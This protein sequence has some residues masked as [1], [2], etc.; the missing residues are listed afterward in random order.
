MRDI[1]IIG[2]GDLGGA[3]AHVLARRHAGTA[4]RLI[5][6]RGRVAE[7]KALDLMQSA[8][9]EGFATQLSGATDLTTAG[10]AN[11]VIVADRA[12]DA[13]WQGED[14]LRLL[15]RLREIA[16]AALILCAGA[17]Q[18]DLVDRGVRELHI[19]RRRIV[20][21]APEALAAGARGLVAL[22]LDG[23]PRDVALTVVGNPPDQTV[24]PWDDATIAGFALTRL[25]DEPLRRRLAGRIQALWPPGPHAL[26]AVAAKALEAASGRTRPVMSCFVAPDD[27]AGRRARTAALPVRLGPR[28]I[29]AVIVPPLNAKDQVALD[30]AMLL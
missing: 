29:E 19:D 16:P 1:A 2:A 6:D 17:S 22:A 14:G 11:V 20:G 26:A 12:G 7:G 30:K 25:V 15:R 23:S 13:E 24:I 21:T 9:V 8:P 4:I 5:D 18:R 10:G 28:G 3:L 27:S